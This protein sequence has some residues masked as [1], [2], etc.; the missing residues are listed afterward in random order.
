MALTDIFL[1]EKQSRERQSNLRNG[2]I[3]ATRDKYP[4][5]FLLCHS[6]HESFFSSR[7]PH[8]PIQLLL[9]QPSH[10]YDRQEGKMGLGK[11]VY[12][13]QIKQRPVSI[14]TRCHLW[15]FCLSHWPGQRHMTTP[16]YKEGQALQCFSWYTA[17]TNNKEIPQERSSK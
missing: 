17:T 4:S 9:L 3:M 13:S 16:R 10:L 7:L 6:Q 12:M 1:T 14:F 8:Y 2:N 15:H 5:T 11:K